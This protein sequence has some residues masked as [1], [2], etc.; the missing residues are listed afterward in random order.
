MDGYRESLKHT[1]RLPRVDPL[2]PP[3]EFDPDLGGGFAS[4]RRPSGVPGDRI[5]LRSSHRL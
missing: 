4:F 3:E 1:L 5:A 2:R